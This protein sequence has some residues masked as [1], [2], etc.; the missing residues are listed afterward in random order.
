MK[1]FT[2]FLAITGNILIDFPFQTCP[3]QKLCKKSRLA[4]SFFVT[5][6]ST[7]NQLEIIFTVNI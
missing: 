7:S 5:S 4:S 6:R 2:T 1:F 3:T